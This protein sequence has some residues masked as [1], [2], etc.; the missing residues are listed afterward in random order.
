[1]DKIVFVPAVEGCL[2]AWYRTGSLLEDDFMFLE[3]RDLTVR[4]VITLRMRRIVM[5]IERTIDTLNL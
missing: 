5:M 2:I 4:I 3:S 1:M